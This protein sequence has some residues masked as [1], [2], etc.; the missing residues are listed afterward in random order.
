MKRLRQ[1]AEAGT[2]TGLAHT[3]EAFREPAPTG[4]RK[5]I[6]LEN[7]R[8]RTE[9]IRTGHYLT[10]NPVDRQSRVEA[11]DGDVAFNVQG[12]GAARRQAARVGQDRV[13]DLY[14]HPLAL[15][16]AALQGATV[17]PPREEEGYEV[18]DVTPAGGPGDRRGVGRLA[19]TATLGAVAR[20]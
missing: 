5:E 3:I 7:G 6:D 4:S 9:Q 15:L 14:H 19:P 16:R 8:W 2:A 11:V 1:P 18:V 17:G 20:T 10:G 12:D 13:A